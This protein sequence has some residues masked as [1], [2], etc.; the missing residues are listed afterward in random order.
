MLP[1]FLVH[2][3]CFFVWFAIPPIHIITQIEVALDETNKC[4]LW[5]QK[6][7]KKIIIRKIAISLSTRSVPLV[8]RTRP[9]SMSWLFLTICLRLQVGLMNFFLILLSLPQFELEEE[10]SL[11]G[12]MAK[13]H[14][15]NAD[16]KK[17]ISASWTELNLYFPVF[18]L[19]FLLFFFCFPS[20]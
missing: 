17:T 16:L 13:A 18:L 14:R 12:R 3:S 9:Y 5:K 2:L 4:N 15:L 11:F 8:I 20:V 19:C 10:P 7:R 6:E 1:A